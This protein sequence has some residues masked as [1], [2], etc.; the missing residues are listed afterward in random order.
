MK[1]TPEIVAE[2][3]SLFASGF[4]G[5]QVAEELTASTGAEFTASAVRNAVLYY[6]TADEH[7]EDSSVRNLIEKRRSQNLTRNVRRDLNKVIDVRLQVEDVLKS[8]KDSAAVIAKTKPVKV[9]P[10]AKVKHIQKQHY[11]RS[12]NTRSQDTSLIKLC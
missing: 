10:T 2:M 8:I 9:V 7:E 5:K 1:W 11:L 12:S 4:T 3:N 6:K